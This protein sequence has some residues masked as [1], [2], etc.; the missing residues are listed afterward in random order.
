MPPSVIAILILGLLFAL[1]AAG[2]P[3]GFAMGLS[4][5]L[6]TLLLIDVNAAL[7]HSATGMM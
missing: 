6:G 4:G 7:A 2:M 1:L 5:F 3:L